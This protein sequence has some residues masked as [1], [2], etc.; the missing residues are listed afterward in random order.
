[1]SSFIY[2]KAIEIMIN[3]EPPTGNHP[4]GS[5]YSSKTVEPSFFGHKAALERNG[6][7]KEHMPF[8]CDVLVGAMK[9][10]RENNNIEMGNENNTLLIDPLDPDEAEVMQ[11]E[12]IRFD[13]TSV[14]AAQFKIEKVM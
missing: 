6:M 13:S 9:L 14:D 5:F 12:G 1:M 3:Q 11:M 4:N 7:I 8:L 10:R 2:N